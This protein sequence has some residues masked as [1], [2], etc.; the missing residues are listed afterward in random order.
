M[1][2]K[3][4]REEIKGNENPSQSSLGIRA[5][6]VSFRHNHQDIGFD[7]TFIPG[8][9]SPDVD[10]SQDGGLSPSLSLLKAKCNYFF[11]IRIDS[12]GFINWND[13]RFVLFTD[14]EIEGDIKR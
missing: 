6:N 9:E 13:S 3:K 11:R 1:E 14:G 7:P 4:R 2:G 10:K 5:W 12:M 8:D